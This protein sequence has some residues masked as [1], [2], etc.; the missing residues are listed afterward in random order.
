MY[1]GWIFSSRSL[2]TLLQKLGVGN[3]DTKRFCTFKISVQQWHGGWSTSSVPAVDTLVE[4]VQVHT[5]VCLH[6][7]NYTNVFWLSTWYDKA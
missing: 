5:G 1:I 4:T 7:F 6:S 2:I 3:R